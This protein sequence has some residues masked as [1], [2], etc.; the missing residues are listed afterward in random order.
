M[1]AQLNLPRCSNAFLVSPDICEFYSYNAGM[2][3]LNHNRRCGIE[4]SYLCRRTEVIALGIY[5]PQQQHADKGVQHAGAA[6]SYLC[7]RAEVVVLGVDSPQQQH[8][9]DAGHKGQHKSHPAHE[10]QCCATPY[11]GVV[12]QQ[13]GWDHGVDDPD[14]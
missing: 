2:T 1:I 4:K 8:G 3:F 10:L 9:T 5:D 7:C 6:K 14:H 11:P 12:D 13:V